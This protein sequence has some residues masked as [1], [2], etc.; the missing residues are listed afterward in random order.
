MEL[1]IVFDG[2]NQIWMDNVNC[3]RTE[4]HIEQCQ[5]NNSN[6]WQWGTHNCNM[7]HSQDIGVGCDQW[8]G[9]GG[10]DFFNYETAAAY[11]MNTPP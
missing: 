5:H 11:A 7:D 1:S 10:S 4:T 9:S 3:I 2:T 6:Q 8:D